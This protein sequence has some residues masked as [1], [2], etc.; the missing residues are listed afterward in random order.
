[1][2]ELESLGFLKIPKDRS[3]QTKQQKL[4]L[5]DFSARLEKAFGLKQVEYTK[6]GDRRIK[7]SEYKQ[8]ERT[9][10]LS[11]MAEAKLAIDEILK[12]RPTTRRFVESIQQSGFDVRPNISE[13]TGRMNGFSFK[14][15]AIKFKSSAIAKNYS[16]QNLQK[17]G[18]D[19]DRLLDAEYLKL[20]KKRNYSSRKI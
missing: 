15:G 13:S 11:V 19:Y 12:D 18:L 14:K 2:S 10:E 1:M 7:S 3:I 5:P 8:M 4:Y 6:S 9:N 20:L 17:N 16:W